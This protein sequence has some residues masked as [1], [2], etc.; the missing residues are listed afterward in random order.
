MLPRIV[1]AIGDRI[2]IHLDGGIRTGQDIFK[3][4]AY[5]AKSTYIGRAFIYGLGAMGQAGVTKALEILAGELDKT[6]ALCGETNINNVGRH[7]LL[8]LQ[9][10]L[11]PVSAKTGIKPV[12]TAA[13]RHA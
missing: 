4:I 2:E 11:S 1:D 6:M 13:K 10:G 3:A 7:N 8:D 5:G 12:K 9:T